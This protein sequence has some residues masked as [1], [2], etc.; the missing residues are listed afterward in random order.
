MNVCVCVCVCLY[1][2]INGC[3][4]MT[5]LVHSCSPPNHFPELTPAEHGSG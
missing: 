5:G 2:Y 3:V 4:V 1:I